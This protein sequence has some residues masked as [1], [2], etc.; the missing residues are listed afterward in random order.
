[1]KFLPLVL[2]FGLL[3]LLQATPSTVEA[4]I[5]SQKIQGDYVGTM[6]LFTG[7]Q[8]KNY[9]YAITI[10]KVSL[11]KK[12]LS[13]KILCADC[14]KKEPF[15]AGCVITQ[16]SPVL[17]FACKGDT[18]HMDYQLTGEHL[19][20]KGITAQGSPYSVSVERER[21]YCKREPLFGKCEKQ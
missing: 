13:L 21:H 20:G 5:D 8:V 10:H 19:K 12:K 4:G 16:V 14:E 2:A 11:D 7:R 18:W 1:M 9:D 3:T 15:M 6:E 17:Q